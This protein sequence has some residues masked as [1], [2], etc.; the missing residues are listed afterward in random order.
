MTILIGVDEAGRGPVIGPMVMCAFAVAE[1]KESLLQN[2]EVKDSKLI[3][4]RKRQIIY[5]NLVESYQYHK[6]VVSVKEIDAALNDE[7][8][9]LNW[10]EAIVSAK[11][12][13]KLIKDINDKDIKII[14]DCPSTNLEAYKNYFTNQ[15][16]KFPEKN[17][18]VISEHKADLNHLCA[19]AASI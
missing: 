13:S 11:A 8:I 17:I 15:L 10:L 9:N 2:L 18:Q 19:G 12:C 6:T 3:A 1:E 14:L 5:E 4:P 16:E 7:T